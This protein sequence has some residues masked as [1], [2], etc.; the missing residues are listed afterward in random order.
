MTSHDISASALVPKRVALSHCTEGVQWWR[1]LNP[2]IKTGGWFYHDGLVD[3]DTWGSI[4]DGQPLSHVWTSNHTPD[5]MNVVDCARKEFGARIVTEIDDDYWSVGKNNMAWNQMQSSR[6][7]DRFINMHEHADIVACSTP[8]LQEVIESR[9]GK[10]TAYAPNFIVPET[11]DGLEP[12]ASKNDDECVLLM[13]GGTGRAFEF[14]E[15]QPAIEAFLAEPNTRVIVMGTFHHWLVP[16]GVSKVTWSRFS[17]VEKYPKI[18]SWIAPDLIISPLLHDDFNLAK[19]NIKWLE[20]AMV[21]G[22]FVGERW[23]EL[24]RTVEDGVTGHLCDGIEE[25][26]EKLVSLARDKKVRT[27]TS[28]AAK[29]VVLS[30]WTWDT[31]GADWRAALGV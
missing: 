29:N 24:E 13:A 23:G 16:Y 6:L 2:A 22:C 9:I 10:P 3:E 4:F 25:W 18:L 15:L 1:M 8:R 14:H 12:R 5:A 7:L 11:W 20:S 31:V 21:G 19:S 17:Q 28:Q 26:T 30:E 27:E